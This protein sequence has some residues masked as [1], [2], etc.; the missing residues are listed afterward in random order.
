MQR[1]ALDQILSNRIITGIPV[2]PDTLLVVEDNVGEEIGQVRR[3]QL[4]ADMVAA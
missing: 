1:L 2:N 4:D 3:L